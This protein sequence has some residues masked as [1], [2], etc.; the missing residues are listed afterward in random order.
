VARRAADR[1]IDETERPAGAAEADPP[2]LQTDPTMPEHVSWTIAK[3]EAAEAS[4]DETP[5]RRPHYA[6][7]V[8][9]PSDDEGIEQQLRRQ[10][11]LGRLLAATAGFRVVAKVRERTV[12]LRL[13]S[14][15]LERSP[16]ARA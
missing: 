5:R 15:A 6:C 10:A 12:V 9:G 14:S 11:E 7:R 2:A 8:E 13:D 16:S 3:R 1:V 4:L